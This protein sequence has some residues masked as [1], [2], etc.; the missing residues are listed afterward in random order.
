MESN[1]IVLP[2][3]E[4]YTSIKI[5]HRCVVNCFVVVFISSGIILTNISLACFV[6]TVGTFNRVI[7]RVCSDEMIAIW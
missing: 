5:A 7:V 4:E 1:S 6:D 2:K 3:G